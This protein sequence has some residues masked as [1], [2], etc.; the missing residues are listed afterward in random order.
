MEKREEWGLESEN[1][2]FV[3]PLFNKFKGKTSSLD[4]AWNLREEKVS[5]TWYY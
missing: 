2:P 3:V 1:Q 4:D 5:M